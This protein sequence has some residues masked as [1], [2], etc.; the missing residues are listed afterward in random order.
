MRQSHDSHVAH[1]ATRERT[2]A[3]KSWE[4]NIVSH[5]NST[6]T[7]PEKA[8]IH[9]WNAPRRT[10]VKAH[11]VEL[12]DVPIYFGTRCAGVVDLI[13]MLRHLLSH[14]YNASRHT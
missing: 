14:L 11:L 1:C 5:E 10:G 8:T 9:I 4:E 13:E 6:K 2:C 12:K 3:S 7:T